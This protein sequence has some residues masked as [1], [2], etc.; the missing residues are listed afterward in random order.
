MNARCSRCDE[1]VLGSV[2]RCWRCGQ[3][4]PLPRPADSVPPQ[5]PECRET[6][7]ALLAEVLDSPVGTDVPTL[8]CGSPAAETADVFTDSPNRQLPNKRP[9]NPSTARQ[10]PLVL[11]LTSLA[12]L[13]GLVSLA[14][15]RN[16]PEASLTLSALGIVAG[17]LALRS[18]GLRAGSAA[19]LMCCFAAWLSGFALAVHLY[20]AT[21]N[22]PP[23]SAAAPR[24]PAAPSISP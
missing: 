21:H 17:C 11:A 18:G 7:E 20:T 2:N 9:S 3:P 24:S 14:L 10:S 5:R 6:N 23:W 13:L 16:L 15:L 8:C 19:L 1:E 4:F 12:L 22:V